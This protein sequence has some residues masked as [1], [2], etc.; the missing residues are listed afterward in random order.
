[1][2]YTP[3]ACRWQ[4][5]GH[6]LPASVPGS[7]HDDLI[8]AGI[9]KDPRLPLAARENEWAALRAWTLKARIPLADSEA[10]R[11]FL[12]ARGVCGR[13]ALAIGAETVAPF[14]S[15][16]WELDITRWALSKPEAV[17]GLRF[18]PDLPSGTPPRV[19][20]AV[21]GGLSLRGVNEARVVRW[22]V[23]PRIVDG[24]G[25]VES[26]VRVCPYAPGRYTFRYAAVFGTETLCVEKRVERLFAFETEL[27]HRFVVPFARRFEPGQPNEPVLLRLTLERAGRVCDDR[28]L[29]TGFAEKTP[30]AFLAGMDLAA[31]ES[32]APSASEMEPRLSLLRSAGLGCVRAYGVQA[33]ALYDALDRNGVLLYQAL[34][35]GEAE[36]ERV[37]ERVLHRPSLIALEMAGPAPCEASG[38]LTP[39]VPVELS[40]PVERP[41]PPAIFAQRASPA[42]SGSPAPDALSTV[43]GSPTPIVPSA[44]PAP[45]IS[46][47]SLA[48]VF[49]PGSLIPPAL[50]GTSASAASP[51]PTSPAPLA[52]PPSSP[53]AA[54]SAP[55]ACSSAPG[56]EQA[57]MPEAF[58]A[59]AHEDKAAIR[60]IQVPPVFLPGPVRP[61]PEGLP[62]DA[63][64]SPHP[65]MPPTPPL[66]LSILRRW[67][68]A[69]LTEADDVARLSRVLQAELVRYSVEQARLFARG[70]FLPDLFERFPGCSPRAL[71]GAE[72]LRPAYYALQSAMRPVHACARFASPGGPCGARWHARIFLLSDVPSAG[73]LKVRAALFRQD[74]RL[75]ADAAFDTA[76]ATADL[77]ILAAPLPEE[78]C[79]L[80]LRLTVERFGDLLDVSDSLLAAS[81]RAPLRPVWRAE[82]ARIRVQ[83]GEVENRAAVAALG[84]VCGAWAHPAYPGYGALLAGEKRA[85]RQENGMEGLNL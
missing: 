8:R 2:P 17:I 26:A 75:I 48:P 18:A 4:G 78:P 65:D 66:A 43:S 36:A 32:D 38:T 81:P 11:L 13:G 9:L 40:A 12:C 29:K 51:P 6:T 58:Y 63:P 79:A 57:L 85:V 31:E 5:A 3:I 72:G 60:S 7:L 53:L 47:A 10:D 56:S 55:L 80:V 23:V 50:P 37:R 16:D 33:D 21:A 30:P 84:V 61:L 73:P 24:Y 70:F 28:M 59:R 71:C 83:N 74:G 41:A 52:P 39:A 14:E 46:S 49:L 15:G 25:V 45:D 1:M 44:P 67:F 64:F 68:G 20:A 54:L 69:D 27:T 22:T 82:K 34:P 19:R 42:S 35:H 77:G 62:P 76:P